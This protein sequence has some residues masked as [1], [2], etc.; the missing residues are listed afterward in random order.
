MRVRK[1][2]AS[3]EE[4]FVFNPTTGDSFSTNPIGSGIIALLKKDVSLK[5]VADEICEKYDVDRILFERDL[6]DFTLQLKEFS[7]LE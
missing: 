2:I 6:E 5:D 7:I 1:N 3:S 4:G